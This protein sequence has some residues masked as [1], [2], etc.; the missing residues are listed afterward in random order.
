[1][2]ITI[3]SFQKSRTSPIAGVEQDYLTRISRYVRVD[4]LRLRRWDESTE[5][6]R[7]LVRSAWRIGLFVDGRERDS[8]AMAGRLQELMSQGRSHLVLVLGAAEGMPK[9]T[10]AQ[11]Q[12][13]GSL[14]QLTFGH[15]LARLVLL[16][17]LYRC[18]DLLH[19]GPYHK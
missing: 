11:M 3:V 13:R 4:Q 5:L 10:A 14:S 9:A 16:E 8:R 15:Q 19:G 12:E 17:A 7:D 6:P 18:F 2:R 1:M